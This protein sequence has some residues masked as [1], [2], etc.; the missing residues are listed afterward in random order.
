[1]WSGLVLAGSSPCVVLLLLRVSWAVC[2]GYLTFVLYFRPCLLGRVEGYFFAQR[3]VVGICVSKVAGAKLPATSTFRTMLRCR[4]CKA[5]LCNIR[6]MIRI[7]L[8][9]LW[10]VQ[11]LIVNTR[12][13]SMVAIRTWWWHSYTYYVCWRL[14]L[15]FRHGLHLLRLRLSPVNL[16]A[17]TWR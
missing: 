6:V 17:G 13:R 16:L 9:L 12:M 5:L 8:E 11:G 10:C 3:C 2:V 7:V 15:L 14:Y 4:G 1:M